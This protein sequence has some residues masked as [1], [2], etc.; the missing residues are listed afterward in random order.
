MPCYLATVN[1]RLQGNKFRVSRN[2]TGLVALL[3]RQPS[4]SNDPIVPRLFGRREKSAIPPFSR[5]QRFTFQ[6]GKKE[7][8]EEKTE[9]RY[10]LTGAV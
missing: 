10:E 2:A 4:F 8:E 9:A 3:K 1:H 6:K 7:E 5:P